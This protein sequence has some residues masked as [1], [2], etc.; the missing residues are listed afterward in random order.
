MKGEPGGTSGRHG[1]KRYNEMAQGWPYIET[2]YSCM[3]RK[4]DPVW[5][6]GVDPEQIY[7]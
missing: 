1:H 4:L 3:Q 2:A 6:Q 5:L 7:R